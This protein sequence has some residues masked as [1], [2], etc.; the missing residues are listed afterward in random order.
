M[1]IPQFFKRTFD[2]FSN[3]AALFWKDEKDLW[4]TLTYGMYKKLIY[5]VAKSF[6]KVIYH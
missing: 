5:D 4:Q 2:H 1:T 3:D 6:L